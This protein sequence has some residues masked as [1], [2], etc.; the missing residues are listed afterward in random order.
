[1]SRYTISGLVFCLYVCHWTLPCFS[2]DV[3]AEHKV[4][5]LKGLAIVAVVIRANTPHEVM[6]LSE[7]GDFLEVGLQR[8][9]TDLRIA[10]PASAPNW[11]ELSIVSTEQGGLAGISVYRWVKVVESGE[12]TMSKV[13]WDERVLL[14]GISKQS[15]Q[16]TLDTLLTAFAADYL[17]AKR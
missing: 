8:R 2:Q 6:S 12:E 15:L 17:R 9:V 16:Q 3:L 13:W 5:G 11:M 10:E 4:R 14:G 7:L 1:M